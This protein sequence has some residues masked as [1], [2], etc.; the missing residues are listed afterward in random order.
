MTKATIDSK[1][2]Y[3][4]LMLTNYTMTRDRLHNI[5]ETLTKLVSP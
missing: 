3:M 4:Q 1:A 5:Y 2:A